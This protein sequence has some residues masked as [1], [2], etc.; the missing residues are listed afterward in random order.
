MYIRRNI[1]L[2]L[3]F[4]DS[5]RFLL[6][7]GLWSAF[8]VYLHDFVGI[9]ILAVPIIPVST[10]G[11]GV[12][13]Y[14]GLKNKEA[15]DRWWEG[16]K[17]WGDIINKSRAF[18]NQVH[19]LL[20]N[21]EHKT[22]PKEVKENLIYR[23]LAWLTALTYQLRATSRLNNK[24]KPKIFQYKVIHHNSLE[25]L[26]KYL[27][28]Q[29]RKELESKSNMASQLIVNQGKALQNL[30]KDGY[31]DSVRHTQINTTLTHLYDT[32][33]KCERIKKTPF[34]RPVAHLGQIFTIIFIILL[35]FSFLDIFQD[36]AKRYIEDE[37][38]RKEYMFAMVPFSMLIAWV[39][40]MMEKVSDSMEDPFESG[41]ND[42]P[43]DSMVRTIEIDLLESLGKDNIP[44]P[45]EAV[46]HV[47]T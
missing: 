36:E 24:T 28:E 10:L 16:R 6:I 30:V 11:I 42:L 15:Y 40:S 37:L 34:P 39:F 43:L 45:I 29:E 26:S 32:Q 4:K 23:H 38:L 2:K 13:L 22:I 33:G 21:E 5:W 12:A 27:E 44:K 46:N 3:L 8:I 41:M 25:P 14:L 35:P 7:I 19:S 9:G 47:L 17:I 31:L 18:S 1:S 20:Y